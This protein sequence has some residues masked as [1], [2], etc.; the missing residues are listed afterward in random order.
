MSQPKRKT[1]SVS[2]KITSSPG[3]EATG[4][5]PVQPVHSALILPLSKNSQRQVQSPPF[6]GLN[7]GNSGVAPVFTKCPQNI[8]ASKGQLVVME[9]RVR[10]TPPLQVWWYRG[11]HLI[12]DSAEFRILTKKACSASV[13]EEVCTLVIAEAFPEDSGVY[14]CVAEN[15]CG[16]SACCAQVTI[17]PEETGTFKKTQELMDHPAAVEGNQDISENNQ[18]PHYAPD[19]TEHDNSKCEFPQASEEQ[20]Y[21]EPIKKDVHEWDVLQQESYSCPSYDQ[22]QRQEKGKEEIGNSKQQVYSSQFYQAPPIQ[23]SVLSDINFTENQ[24]YK[25]DLDMSVTNLPSV[26]SLCQPSMFNYERPKHFIQSQN[27]SQLKLQTPATVTS[28]VPDVQDKHVLQAP[29]NSVKKSTIVLHPQVSNGQR[30][31]LSSSS[32]LSSPISTS[33]SSPSLG[34]DAVFFSPPA[35]DVSSPVFSFPNAPQEKSSPAAFLCS[36][37]PSQP[38]QSVPSAKTSAVHTVERNYPKPA[39]KKSRTPV[40]SSD[41]QIQGSKDALIQD[42]ERKLRCRDAILHNGNQRLTYEEKMARRLLGPDNVASV[43]ET[44]NTDNFQDTTQRSSGTDTL[45]RSSQPRSRTSSRGEETVDT[46]VHEKFYPPRFLQV[47]DDIIVEEGRFLRIDFKVSGLPTPDVKWFLDGR[48]V[49]PDD[50]H[51][52][53]VSEKGL[54]SFIFEFVQEYDAGVYECVA[55]NRAGFSTFH[56][57]L[58]VVAQQRRKAPGFIQK[59]Q[60]VTVYEGDTARLECQVSAVPEPQIFWKKDNEMIEFNTDRISMFQDYTGKIGLL[61]HDV[62]K[63]DAGWYT[64]SA[65]NDAGADTCH[66]RLDVATYI[67]RP[68]PGSKQLKMRPSLSKYVTLNCQGIDVQDAFLPDTD[69]YQVASY[70]GLTESEE[71]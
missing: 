58:D 43:F 41:E 9:C 3:N 68:A 28:K 31:S 7:R 61:I 20:V 51:K 33:S 59:P 12:K 46:T 60:H 55:T 29:A 62:N 44:E 21:Y 47:P 6:T 1:T 23:K 13:P 15:Q 22:E 39:V 26:S 50:F 25:A 37:L 65:L 53:L 14:K 2:L 52:M 56:L 38:Q 27:K 17:Y 70:G 16:T 8:C 66:A 4:S 63:K 32:S 40:I 11:N 19:N 54:H 10:A 36:V 67:N 35:Y 24:N 69:V 30:K 49:R 71:L 45:R 48:P 64:V 42:L 18:L 34:K 57:V 5:N